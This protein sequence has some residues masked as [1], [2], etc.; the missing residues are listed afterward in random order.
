MLM[1][2]ISVAGGQAFLSNSK[3]YDKHKWTRKYLLDTTVSLKRA[4]EIRPRYPVLTPRKTA[5]IFKTAISLV[6][7]IRAHQPLEK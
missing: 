2:E 1:G 4:T 7:Y 6:K 5:V 3:N